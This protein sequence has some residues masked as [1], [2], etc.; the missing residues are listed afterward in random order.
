MPVVQPAMLKVV[1]LLIRAMAVRLLLFR[2]RM[3]YRHQA[4]RNI[5]LMLMPAVWLAQVP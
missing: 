5:I 1:R 3:L 4:Q 2:M